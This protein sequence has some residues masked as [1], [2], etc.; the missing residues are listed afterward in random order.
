MALA[1]SHTLCTVTV[2]I[3]CKPVYAGPL[4]CFDGPLFENR[5]VQRGPP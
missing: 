4:T 5:G 2:R 3:T 1:M